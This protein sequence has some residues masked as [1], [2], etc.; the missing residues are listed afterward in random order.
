[1]AAIYKRELSSYFRTFIGWLFL[2][3][4]F[5]MMG[6]YFTVY[7]LLSGYPTISYILQSII[8]LFVITIPILTMRSLAEE[9]RSRTDQLLLTSPVSVTGI[10]LGKYFALITILAIPVVLLGITPF[11]LMQAGEFQLGI[12]YTSLLGFFL[13]GALAAAIG[14]FLSSLTENVIISAVLSFA[15]L[16][17]GYIM[18]GLCN[19]ISVAGTGKISELLV[20]LLGFFNLVSRFD[21]LCSGYFELESVVYYVTFSAF[22][23]FLTTQSIQKR[24]YRISGKGIRLGAYSMG[25]ILLMAALLAAANI[26][27]SLLPEKYTSFDVTSN[28]VFTLTEDTK[29]TLKAIE[30]D[31]TIYV[32][33]EEDSKDTDLDKTLQQMDSLSKHIQ[34]SYI[35]PVSNPKFY[36]NYTEVQPT[37]NSLIVVCGERS[38]VVDYGD[39]YTSELDYTTYEMKT[40]GY[41]GE[42]QLVSAISYVLTEEL[43]VFYTITGHNELTFEAAFANAITKENVTCEELALYTVDEIPDTAEGIIINA[44]TSDFS[45]DDVKKVLAFLEKGKNAL[46]IPTWTEEPLPN[47]EKILDYYGVSLVDGMIVEGDR[48]YYY[49]QSPYYLIPSIQYDAITERIQGQNVFSPFS[50][51]LSYDEDSEEI[52]YTPLLKTSES[53]FSKTDISDVSNYTKASGDAQGPF[54]IS[55]KAEKSTADGEETKAVIVASESIFTSEADA[56]F[57]GNNLTLM[58][59]VISAL[60]EYERSVSIPAKSYDIGYLSFN[61]QISLATGVFAAIVLPLSCL[62]IGFIIWLKRRKK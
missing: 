53:A 20:K 19:I 48:N 54:V 8:F 6:I 18:G 25:G 1:M 46:L 14:L 30:Q 10:V 3:V 42:G 5:F 16:F 31:V 43:P 49:T 4:T 27:I 62:L 13:Y 60:A 56:I 57:P 23:L 29:N 11:V 51:G 24:R 35:S 32:L 40:T 45:E 47:F 55:L 59:S 12:S 21:D 44:P 36:Y 22:M 50:K 33:A 28:K 61:A 2:A 58:G 9:R 17:V 52:H 41:D 34:V 7:N 26:G 37:S 38:M 15:A 39:I